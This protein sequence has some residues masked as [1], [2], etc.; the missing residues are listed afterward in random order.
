MW[1]TRKISSAVPSDTGYRSPAP[2]QSDRLN[3]TMGT[4]LHKR[5]EPQHPLLLSAGAS[6]HSGLRGYGSWMAWVFRM[7]PPVTHC[8]VLFPVFGWPW[9]LLSCR[10]GSSRSPTRPYQE[11]WA[12]RLLCLSLLARYGSALTLGWFDDK[13]VKLSGIIKT[14]LEAVS[15]EGSFLPYF[16]LFPSCFSNWHLDVFPGHECSD[17]PESQC[18]LC[19]TFLICSIS[20]PYLSRL[21][22]C[23]AC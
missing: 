23:D 7:K 15:M 22:K 20:K 9:D 17:W 21:M 19:P 2:R 4:L 5:C 13:V 18:R 3:S 6:G 16:K 1:C 14:L 12:R 11:S 8:V 10:S